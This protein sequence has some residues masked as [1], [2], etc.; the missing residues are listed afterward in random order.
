[1]GTSCHVGGPWLVG[2]CRGRHLVPN[3][4]TV[5]RQ[6]RL[7]KP[8]LVHAKTL[9]VGLLCHGGTPASSVIDSLHIMCLALTGLPA[10]SRCLLAAAPL[11]WA[12][13]CPG[14]SDSH[15]RSYAGG[16]REPIPCNDSKQHLMRRPHSTHRI[17]TAW[18]SEFQP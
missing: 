10:C 17:L 4:C 11:Q 9:S 7:E 3:T 12:Q 13:R 1:M 8:T 16:Q 5:H 18:D 6:Y 14:C 15:S 2:V